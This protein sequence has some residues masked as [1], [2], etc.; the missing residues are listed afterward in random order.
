[1][2]L[3][4][5][6]ITSTDIS[7]KGVI[8]APD[9][10]TGTAAEN[11]AIFDRL[12]RE[13]V[14]EVVNGI[15]DDLVAESGASEIGFSSIEGVTAGNVQAAVTA[16]KAIADT[17]ADSDIVEADLDLKADKATTNLHFKDISLNSETGV[18]T[19][20]RENGTTK[21]IDTVLEKVATNWEYVDTAEHPQSLKLT[22]ADGTVQYV[23]LSAFITETEFNDS[24]QIAFSVS[25]HKVTATIKSGCITDT[26]LSSTL[27]ALMQGYVTACAGSATA[28]AASEANALT[29]KTAAET[30]KDEAAASATAA[31]NSATAAGNAETNAGR[32]ALKSEGHAT[33]TQNGEPVGPDSDYYNNNAKYWAEEAQRAAG[34]G[35]SSFNGRSGSVM[36]ANNDYSPSQ[37]GL[38][39]AINNSADI[40][41]DESTYSVGA[42]V[43]Y[44]NTLYECATAVTTAEEFDPDK[45]QARTFEELLARK[46]DK[47]NV[48]GIVKNNSLGNIAKAIPGL[49]YEVGYVGKTTTFNANG[50]ITETYANGLVKLTTFVNDSTI[51]E[52]Y[53]YDGVTRTKTTVFNADGSITETIS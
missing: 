53:T 18:I 14:K 41:S 49:D 34:G 45:W 27:L 37:V 12:I 43:I 31:N 24:D 47:F 39:G 25:G 28:A 21:A 1:M 36:P 16:L 9:K 26:M 44:N 30:A 13:I 4:N 23:S 17:K 3:T 10:L 19:L 20:T 7:T 40:Y 5:R 46:Q 51:T 50:T 42:V 48:G 52:A 11:K 2:A 32:Q 29:Y 15:V 35:V 33:G 8:A 38:S 6:K 22:L